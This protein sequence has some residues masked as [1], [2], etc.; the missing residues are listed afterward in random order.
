M[1]NS[2]QNTTAEVGHEG[3]HP[4]FPPF[5]ARTFPSQLLWFALIF[6]GMYYYLSKRYLP[7]VGKLIDTRKARIAKDIDEATAL[8][9]QAEAAGAEQDKAI[10]AARAAGQATAQAARDKIAAETEARRQA[11]EGEL[12]GKLAQAEARIAANRTAAMANV[13]DIAEGAT[14]AIVERLLGR[15]P[16]AASVKKAVQA[17]A[18]AGA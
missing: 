4:V 2:P 8:H 10:A 5:D 1:A 3:A 16:D 18:N 17:A 14:G 6:G 13:A 9:A 7:A 15:A 11:L 12:N